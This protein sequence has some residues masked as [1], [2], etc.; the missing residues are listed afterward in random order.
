MMSRTQRILIVDDDPMIHKLIEVRIRDLNVSIINASDGASG[1][2]L[3][4]SQHP[5][6]ILLDVG[7]PDMTGFS[8]CSRL[9]DDPL[10]RE[11]PIIFLTGTDEAEEKVRAFEMGAV[12]YVTKPFNPAELRARVRAALRTQ[13]LLEALE[14][15]AMSDH[16]T[17]LPNRE[18]F[19]RS[20]ARC[21][22]YAR[23]HP[24]FK[25][26]LMFLDLDR[27]KNINDSLGHAAGD[28]LLVGVANRLYQCVFSA[29]SATRGRFADVVARLGGDEFAILLHDAEHETI[30][31]I[32]EQIQHAMSQPH[33]LEGHHVP[34]SAS[35]GVRMADGSAM[36][37]D[38][39]LRDS[40]TAM[41][42][43]K[44]AGKGRCSIFEGHM[45]ERV[46]SRLK[47]EEGIRG[48]LLNRELCVH[49]QPVLDL[50]TRKTVSLEALVR[51]NH[52]ELGHVEP[53]DFLPVAEESGDI[54]AI[55]RWVIR[56]ACQDART[57]SRRFR[58]DIQVSVNI[59]RLELTTDTFVVD[60]AQMLH[61]SGVSP[62]QLMLEVKDYI[63]VH[64]SRVVVPALNRLHDLGVRLAMDDFGTGFS[65]LVSLHRFPIDVMKI[66]REFVK[67]LSDNRPYAA[68]LNAIVTLAHNLDLTV[69]AK[70]VETIEQLALL[71]ALDCDQAQGFRFTEPISAEEVEAYLVNESIPA[72]A[73]A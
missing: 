23:Q 5:H 56:Q 30:S 17:G 57:W 19:R 33:E 45:H 70:G 6:L 62:S 53:N 26:A 67:R 69:I 47:L 36:S 55:G 50:R 2:A 3:A 63:L 68:I 14:V 21:I 35:I 60:L 46:V 48:A 58:R 18:A 49:Y 72:P 24:G 71:Q 25:F 27:F 44:H 22:E 41:Y 37:V 38:E 8:V 9:R 16:L 29:R 52:P 11:I 59:S 43:A 51:W 12:D 13:S 39:L 15:Q 4:H 28:D 1:I 20:V 64:E 32:A 61:E 65:S 40:D 66:D 34:C 73:A 31:S 54:L 7:L 10:T 42:H